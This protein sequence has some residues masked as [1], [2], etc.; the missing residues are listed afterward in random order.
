MEW[1]V[2][3]VVI[4][5]VGLGGAIVKPIASLT[6]SITKLTVVVERVEKELAEQAQHSHESHRRLWEHNAEQDGRLDDH[7]MRIDR[8]E[9]SGG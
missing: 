3:T 2:V 7:E 5:L 1:T 8:L 9:R 6:G 4:A